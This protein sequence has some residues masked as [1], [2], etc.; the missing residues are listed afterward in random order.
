[1]KG[2]DVGSEERFCCLGRVQILIVPAWTE[3]SSKL[4]LV[5]LKDDG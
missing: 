1:M 2:A 3:E 4:L 5:W